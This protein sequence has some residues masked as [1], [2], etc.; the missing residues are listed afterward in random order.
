MSNEGYRRYSTSEVKGELRK[1]KTWKV[2][3]GKLHKELEFRT[4]DDAMGFMIRASLEITKL[5]HHPEWFN[6]YN[7][8]K[9]DLVTHDLGGISDYDFILAKKLD[10]VAKLF[11]TK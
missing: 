8:V 1:L 11:K 5:N 3:K 10:E 9:I 4:F 6:V 2:V 7:I